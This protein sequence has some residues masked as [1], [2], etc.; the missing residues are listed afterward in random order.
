M[1][2]IYDMLKGECMTKDYPL[3]QSHNFLSRTK[4][5][6]FCGHAIGKWS[7]SFCGLKAD[8]EWWWWWGGM[9]MIT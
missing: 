4:W 6:V 8:E 5:V 2:D 9:I 1:Y 7:V 3:P